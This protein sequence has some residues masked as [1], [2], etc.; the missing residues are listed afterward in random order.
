[1]KRV[2]SFTIPAKT[3][4]AFEV[5]QGQHVRVVELEGPQVCDFDAFNLHDPR[6]WFYSAGTRTRVGVHPRQGHQL[7]TRP[8]WERPMFTI[9]AD[10]VQHQPS[11]SGAQAH[12][13]IFSRCT[14]NLQ[15]ER[16]G[17]E[18]HGCQQNLAAAIAPFGLDELYVHDPLNLFMKTGIRPDGKPFHELPDARPGDYVELRA[19]MDCLVAISACPGMSSGG[20][21]YPLGIEIYAPED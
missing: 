4:R 21:H 16:Y 15:R 10:T 19:E 2:A 5:R 6:E 11:P 9:V 17:R 13:L 1:M 7:Y 18:T 8:P 12:D 3:G 20:Q 14:G